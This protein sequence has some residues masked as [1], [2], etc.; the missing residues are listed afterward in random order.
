MNWANL[1]PLRR[2]NSVP[3][4]MLRLDEE[5]TPWQLRKLTPKAFDPK[6][7]GRGTP[8]TLG[9]KSR[10]VIP[11]PNGVRSRSTCWNDDRTPMGL[12]WELTGDRDPGCAEYRDPG[13]RDT[14]P[15]A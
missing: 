3:I 11:Y 1:M 14:T 7:L 4:R 10:R 6:A 13:L 12:E 8:R 2:M 9:Y 5:P 15:A